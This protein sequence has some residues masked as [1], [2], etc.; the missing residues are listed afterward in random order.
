MRAC[1]AEKIRGTLQIKFS[2]PNFLNVGTMIAMA[3]QL[4]SLLIFSNLL[5]RD[6][7]TDFLFYLIHTRTIH[8]FISTSQILEMH[9]HRDQPA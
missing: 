5:S 1:V 7:L 9:M 6:H 3:P 2:L 8:S 4:F